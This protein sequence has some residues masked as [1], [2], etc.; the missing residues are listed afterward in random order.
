M[1]AL[2]LTLQLQPEA[3]RHPFGDAG[4]GFAIGLLQ[5]FRVRE[6]ADLDLHIDAIE[7]RTGDFSLVARD[8]I[9]RAA[10]YSFSMAEKAAWA[11]IHGRDQ[12]KACREIG[13]PRRTRDGNAA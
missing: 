1:I 6:R 11:G 2:L 10:A 7:Q 4:G 8:L 3:A 13:L 12:L 5:Q 9:R